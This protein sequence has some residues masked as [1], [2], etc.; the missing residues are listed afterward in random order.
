MNIEPMLSD[1]SIA[2]CYICCQTTLKDHI[3]LSGIGVHCG[4]KVNLEIIPASAGHG[5]VF[6][7]KDIGDNAVEIPVAPSSVRSAQLC[8]VI[9]THDSA[10][11][12]TVEHLLAALRGC[13]IDNARIEVDGPEIPILDGSARAFV[14][15]I[16]DVGLESLDINRRAI[17]VLKPIEITNGLAR[18][19]FLPYDGFKLDIE[20]E[21]ANELIGIQQFKFE[22]SPETFKRELSTARTF[23][24][25]EHAEV[26]RAQGFALG[27]SLDNTV[28]ISGQEILNE[29]GLRFSDEFVRHK[30]LDAI[31]DLAIAGAP[32]LGMYYSHR[33][34]HQ[35]NFTAL[36]ALL[37][38]DS[39]WETIEMS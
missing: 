26:L 7:R 9:G 3:R 27:A 19:G 24:F 5:I 6:I 32:I 16:E 36:S 11:V 28:V 20:I 8:T 10:T 15:A 14:E 37:Q 31:G 12:S 23:G 29:E 21:F 17:R 34:G 22:W 38:D 33:G 1:A 30:A 4:E 2:D 18:C 25:L 13:G 39:A 35:A